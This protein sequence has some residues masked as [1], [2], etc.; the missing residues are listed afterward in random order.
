MLLVA[1]LG[2]TE[3]HTG[4]TTLLGLLVMLLCFVGKSVWSRLEKLES[5]KQELKVKTALLEATVPEHGTRLGA[6]ELVLGELRGDMREAKGDLRRIAEW[7][8]N[9][10]SPDR[11]RRSTDRKEGD[12]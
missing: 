9:Q 2:P 10:S 5:E 1:E 4:A 3:I 8:A 11:H 12:E 6:V 7:V